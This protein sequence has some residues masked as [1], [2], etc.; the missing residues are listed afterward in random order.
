MNST[1]AAQLAVSLEV[2]LRKSAVVWLTPQGENTAHPTRLVWAVFSPRGAPAGTLFVA[3][4]GTEQR[5]DG[6]VDGAVV[7]VVVAR[8]G[9]RSAMTTLRCTAVLVEDESVVAAALTTARRNARPG[10]A[11]VFALDLF[12]AA[13]HGDST[14]R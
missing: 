4:G 11:E 3:C 7:D 1:S 8:P 6:L 12:A 2:A 9:T 13:A 10:W 14:G 5:V